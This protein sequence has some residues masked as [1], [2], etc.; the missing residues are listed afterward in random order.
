MAGVNAVAVIPA[1]HREG[2]IGWSVSCSVLEGEK[3]AFRYR[4]L[5]SGHWK[6][7]SFSQLT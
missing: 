6:L 3:Q 1:A 7:L 5:S 2:R 4:E